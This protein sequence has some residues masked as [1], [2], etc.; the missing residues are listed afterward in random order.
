MT[1]MD[2]AKAIDLT[3]EQIELILDI[4]QAING[5][6]INIK[7]YPPG[8]AIVKMA[9]DRGMESYTKFFMILPSVTF[10][11]N[12]QLLLVDENLLNPKIQQKA[13]VI[14]F[15]AQLR[16]RN[17]R[18]I[19]FN[20]GLD[21]EEM[22]IFLQVLS[23]N[24]DT[25]K[26]IQDISAFL[27]QKGV[28]H[29]EVDKKRFV[30]ISKD[31]AVANI[32]DLERMDSGSAQG[33][34]VGEVKDGM[35][36]SYMLTKIP[37][38]DLAL[39]DEDLEKI[40]SNIDYDRLKDAGKIDFERLGPLFA[41]SLE[42]MLDLEE[43]DFEPRRKTPRT[44]AD[45]V[46]AVADEASREEYR[47][48]KEGDK[49]RDERVEKLI[50]TFKTISESIV[51]FKNPGV[52]AKL[53]NDFIKIITNF[54]SVT[55][56]RILTTKL[57]APEGIDMKSAIITQLTLQKKSKIVDLIMSRFE[58]HVEGLS[59][60]DFEIRLDELE[61][62]EKILTQVLAQLKTSGEKKQLGDRVNRG[63]GLAR[64]I[65][66]EAVEGES[67]LIL[68]MR[69]LINKPPQ[70]FLQEEFLDN[71]VEL[72]SRLK[73]ARRPDI[74]KKILEKLAEN[75]NAED[76][77]FR[78]ITINAFVGVQNELFSAGHMNV[79]G[80]C[81]NQLFKRMG[82]EPDPKVF[83]LLLA[84]IVAGFSKLVDTRKYN[85]A[86][87]IIMS[88]DRLKKMLRDT[89]RKEILTEGLAS[90]VRNKEINDR[91]IEA[92]KSEDDSM[93]DGAVKVLMT[94]PASA[95][96]PQ[97]LE[98]LKDSDN[99][100]IRKK[101]TNFIGKY[102]TAIHEPIMQELGREQPWYYVRN[103][104]NL[105]SNAPGEQIVQTVARHIHHNDARVRKAC[106]TT[107]IKTRNHGADEI[108]ADAILDEDEAITKMIVSHFGQSRSKPGAQALMSMLIDRSFA[109]SKKDLCCEVISAIARIGHPDSTDI[110]IKIVKP[111]GLRGLFQ[112][113]D[114]V[115]LVAVL[116]AFA[117]IRDPK[118]F[119][120]VKKYV[121]DKNPEVAKAA[122]IAVQA[123]E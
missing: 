88:L 25:I 55:L 114:E 70:F 120:F 103:L 13:F 1:E 57:A 9:L 64:L 39:S 104:V 6:L 105:L 43:E 19:T 18:S 33:L 115:I 86:A 99:M 38:R 89:D 52:R 106:V 42:K 5:T 68:K 100:R 44:T 4:V 87:N 90:I 62:S 36:L 61:E 60:D 72:V 66:K 37:V 17:I 101:S 75:L 46:A 102:G 85:L 8:S 110:L 27:A 65:K 79:V 7:R 29:V 45:G 107:L 83:A 16:A 77:Q 92:F 69:H 14:S 113:R 11:E 51:S 41:A 108:L 80:D 3:D 2:Q 22:M 34:S 96:I 116:K 26:K 30:A 118:G 84:S 117:L 95:I 10:S 54:K 24:P 71:F 15:L 109:E 82:K 40:K 98:V 49:K 121:R 58:Q 123:M 20:K 12:E 28:K 119:T 59:A 47:Q 31:Q 53:L 73:S 111:G 94:I 56:A 93:S 67:L 48:E 112:K 78:M 91:L 76:P 81:Y 74:I 122:K 21:Q 97:L 32:S 63:M 50:N 35:F 23:E